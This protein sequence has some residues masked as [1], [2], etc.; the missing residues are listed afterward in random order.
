[1]DQQ[2]QGY[3]RVFVPGW[4]QGELSRL[5]EKYNVPFL[6]GPKEILDLAEFFGQQGKAKPEL[7]TYDIEIIAE[8][9]HAP[10]M[11]DHEIF[12]LAEHYRRSGANVIDIGCIPGESWSRI[13]DVVGSLRQD[14]FRISIDSF[15]RREVES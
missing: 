15:D 5:T 11:R 1:L 2:P 7:E 8:I 13:R 10:R 6:H 3:D 4:C 14:G 12:A 9:N